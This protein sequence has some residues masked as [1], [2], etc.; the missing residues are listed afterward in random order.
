MKNILRI[1]YLFY[2]KELE[3][4][5]ISAGSLPK[6]LKYTELGWFIPKPGARDYFQNSHM[7]ART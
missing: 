7:G 6:W 2:L 4:D 5:F 1:I 3:G